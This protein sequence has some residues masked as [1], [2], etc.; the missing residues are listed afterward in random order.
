MTTTIRTPA[1]W[2][3]TNWLTTD[4]LQ[5]T[6][7]GKVP[8]QIQIEILGRKTL[9]L[10]FRI[11][12]Y[13]V[14]NYRVL[15]EIASDGIT[16]GNFSA[17]SSASAD[18]AVVN[19]KNDILEKY[20]EAAGASSEWVQFDAGT[21]RTIL[22]DTFALLATN[23]TSSAQLVLKG[24]G[25][26]SDAAPVSWVSVPVY[27]TIAMPED[28]PDEDR[29]IWIA[30]SIP[31]ETFRHWRLEISDPSNPSPVRIGRVL[32]G[33][34][35]VLAG[36]NLLVDVTIRRLSFKD[37]MRLTGFTS[38][39]NNRALKRSVRVR[40]SDLNVLNKNNY[41]AL[42]KM[43]DYCRDTLKVLSIPDP[44]EPYLYSTFAKIADLPEETHQFVDP[45][46]IYANFELAFDESR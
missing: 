7:K 19:V 32:G 11:S 15:W 23:L 13:N 30:P 10:Q 36:E 33:S 43:M 39:A 29:V 38:I 24:Y 22:M 12:L 26:G 9:G 5:N 3:T 28:R 46:T 2:L 21:N 18:K 16:T 1:N 4:W 17:S 8:T 45:E 35:S 20:W 40:F 14:T 44:R 42:A 34:A 6:A 27:A 37:E 25:A 31:T 41:Q